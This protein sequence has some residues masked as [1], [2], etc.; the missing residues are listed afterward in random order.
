MLAAGSMS[1]M[2]KHAPPAQVSVAYGLFL[3][4]ALGIWHMMA[5]GEFSAILTVSAM[6]QCLAVSL[7]AM[8]VMSGGGAAG[9]SAKALA[10]DAAGF[11][12]RLSS[13]TWLQGYLPADITGDWLYQVIDACSLALTLWL[14]HRV[15]VTERTTYSADDDSLP[16]GP[17]L[18]GALL[19]AAVFH[20]DLND[21]PLFDTLW[22]AGLFTGTVAVLPQLWLISRKG[23]HVQ[24]LTSHY[25]AVMALSRACSGL[26]MWHCRE[27]L[28]SNQWIGG[29]EHAPWA[30]LGAHAVH[31]VLLGDFAY[32]YVK[33]VATQGLACTFEPAITV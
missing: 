29:W 7:L 27:D 2:A 28:T 5:E 25:V 31:L 21:R 18:L 11:A 16:I 19:L 20:A 12:F 33:A 30:I 23:G 14:L 6:L 4:V 26:F 32:Y 1:D 3:T 8:Q 13:T 15:L 22:M 10:L 17:L 9:V 24:A